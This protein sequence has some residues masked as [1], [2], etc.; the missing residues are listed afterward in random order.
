[1]DAH[2]AAAAVLFFSR[3]RLRHVM[4][5][6]ELLLLLPVPNPARSLLF[7]IQRLMRTHLYRYGGR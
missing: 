2:A 3:R 7:Q 6:S 5:V 4:E 1:M